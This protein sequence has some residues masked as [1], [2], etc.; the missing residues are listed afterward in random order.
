MLP[1]RTCLNS[2]SDSPRKKRS[3][4]GRSASRARCRMASRACAAI[5]CSPAGP[6]STESARVSGSVPAA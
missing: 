2:A 4:G 1:A 5:L 3:A 6:A